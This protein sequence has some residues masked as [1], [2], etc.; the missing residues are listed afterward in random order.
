MSSAARCSPTER[1]F[2]FLA[3]E[4][5]YKMVV[6]HAHGLH[7][8]IADRR[9]HKLE[10]A[11]EKVLTHALGVWGLCGNLRRGSRRFAA[12]PAA[13]KLPNVGIKAAS[14]LADLK[15]GF[16]VAHRRS[17]FQP[18]AHDARVR[19]QLPHVPGSIEG[20]ALRIK[21]AERLSIGVALA[22][23]G[24]PAQASLGAFEYEELK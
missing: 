11:A 5:G 8:G 16:R 23:N 19:K 20:H 9:P 18:V 1:A 12:R 21:V 13:G 3:A 14:L 4:A 6:H 17:D 22:E 7:I 2:D 15:E 24:R 10:A